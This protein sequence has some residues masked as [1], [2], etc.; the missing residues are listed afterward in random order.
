MTHSAKTGFSSFEAARNDLKAQ[1]F[2]AVG[3]YAREWTHI[4]GTVF[5]IG[6]SLKGKTG[7]SAR[8]QGWVFGYHPK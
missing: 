7:Q 5:Q 8:G 2:T 6:G 4:D 3:P 1:G